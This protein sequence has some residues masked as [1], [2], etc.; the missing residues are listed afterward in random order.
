MDIENGDVPRVS[1][2]GRGIPIFATAGLMSWALL[3]LILS[4]LA[5]LYALVIVARTFLRKKK[6]ERNPQGAQSLGNIR[7]MRE[8]SV[9]SWLRPGWLAAV[10][11][12][13][14]TSVFLFPLTEN[15]KNAMVLVDWW[16]LIHAV[17][18]LAEILAVN[19]VFKKRA[20]K[21]RNN[22]HRG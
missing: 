3:N 13:A 1:F 7:Y 11:I 21:S 22:S 17:I 16:T 20:E 5:A 9:Y 18:F 4:G 12:M 14:I 2:G 15:M 10:I 6:G 19:F 8:D